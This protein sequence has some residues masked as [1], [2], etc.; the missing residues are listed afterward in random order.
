MS[1]TLASSR[2]Q[3]EGQ[4]GKGQ[5]GQQLG[6]AQ[7]RRGLENFYKVVEGFERWV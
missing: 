7:H 1:P 3:K 4:V 5:G 6:G 2:L